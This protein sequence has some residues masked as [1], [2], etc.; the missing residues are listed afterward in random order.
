MK[1]DVGRQARVAL[2][3]HGI[4]RFINKNRRVGYS[5]IFFLNSISII[6]ISNQ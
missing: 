5:A 1:S 6:T 2:A 3:F 4:D